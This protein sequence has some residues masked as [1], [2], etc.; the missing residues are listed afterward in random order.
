MNCLISALSTKARSM[1][2]VML[3]VV[4]MMTLGCSRSLSSCVSRAFT[5]RIASDGSVPERAAFL[6]AVRLS[7]SSKVCQYSH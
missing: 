3:D 1:A 2:P 5:T 4:K 6:A 7:T